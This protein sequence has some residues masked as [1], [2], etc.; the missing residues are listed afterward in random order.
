MAT[1]ER[2]IYQEI[3]P[4]VRPK[5]DP[6]Y[7]EFHDKYMQYVPRDESKEW[8]GSARTTPSLPPGGSKPVSIGPIKDVKIGNFEARVFTPESDQN[9]SYGC[10]IWFHGGGWAIGGLEDS[11]D[12]C[13]Y[14]CREARCVVV[15]VAYRLSPEHPYPAPVEDAVDALDWVLGPGAQQFDIDPARIAVGG[16]SAGANL[17]IVLCL[18]AAERP[19]VRIIFQLLIVPVVD[20]TATSE[21]VWKPNQ[22]A[23]WLTP[24]RMLW[25]R[26][27]YLP[28]EAD[29]KNWDASPNLAPDNL[30]E[31][32]PPTWMAVSEQDL[33]APEAVK[34][35]AQLRA[36]NVPVD[37]YT[38]EGGTHS[39]LAL[40][41]VLKKGRAMMNQAAFALKDALAA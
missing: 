3:H 33:L 40:N 10:L 34:F 28:N 7:V 31:R 38:V 2:T 5:L 14:L 16:T 27:M 11:P 25:Y 13:A 17:S 23:P 8:D 32:I 15:S 6:E 12:L 26:R 41:G 29:W 21:G 9:G 19:G 20:N 39:I 1:Q 22:N 35:A 37:V 4:D 36:L 30:L 18:K 24:S